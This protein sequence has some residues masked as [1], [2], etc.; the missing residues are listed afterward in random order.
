MILIS[1][2]GSIKRF[3]S[4]EEH[5]PGA[6]PSQARALRSCGSCSEHTALPR[7]SSPASSY[8]SELIEDPAS[9]AGYKMST[10]VS[11]LKREMA[12]MFRSP[13]KLFKKDK[14]AVHSDMS[15]LLERVEET[16]KRQDSQA[17]AIKELQITMKR[18]ALAH[19]SSLY[20][21]EDFENRNCRNNLRISGL[22]EA[23]KDSD[24]EPMIRG[25]LNTILR[26]SVTDPLRFDRVHMALRPCNL[27]TDLPR[28]VVC[29]L[30]YFE[31][32]NAIVIKL[33][34][35]PSIDFDG[36]TLS[37]FPDL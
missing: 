6:W 21:L 1:S 17:A 15:H 12:G 33:C 24:L 4:A 28:D 20:K 10:L 22:P 31:Q 32:K 7:E 18:L 2:S 25:I 19:R 5:S 27:T 11:G 34:G 29:H 23:T 14:A 8:G 16:E 26:K 9:P 13:E 3:L 36:A 37:V 35:T 30:H